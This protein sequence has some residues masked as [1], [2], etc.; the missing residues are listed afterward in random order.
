MIHIDIES[1]SEINVNKVG[2]YCY[3]AHPSTEILCVA[4]AN[5]DTS[6]QIWKPVEGEPMPYTL[7]EGFLLGNINFCAHNAQFERVMFNGPPGKKLSI[8][9]TA[10]ERWY[11]TAAKAAYHSLPRS[12]ENCAR[13][14]KCQPK[15]GEGKFAMYAISKPRKPTVNNKATRFLPG[16]FP[17]K[18]EVL[19]KYCM[20]DVETERQID[21]TLPALP[22]FERATFLMDQKINERGIRVDKYL[23]E[24]IVSL[25]QTQAEDLK[26]KFIDLTGFTPKQIQKFLPW[27]RE[28]GYPFH[29][30]T[31][32]SVNQAL[33]NVK[34]EMDPDLVKALQI[35]RVASKSSIAK[36]DAVERS[37]VSVGEEMSYDNDG[38][39][40]YT[41]K[42]K[43]MFLYHGASTGRWAGKIFQPHNLPR[44]NFKSDAEVQTAINTIREYD[45]AL[46][47]ANYD[48][49]NALFSA[50][51]RSILIPDPGKKFKVADF[52]SIEARVLGWI[53]REEGYLSAFRNKEDL[54][55]NLAMKIYQCTRE[56]VTPDRRFLGKTGILALGYGMGIVKF[57][58]TCLGYGME[59]PD[60]LLQ[61]ALN[62][63]RDTYKTIVSFWRVVEGKAIQA[64]QTNQ[65]QYLNG[66]SF[67][68]DRNFL[69]IELP[70]RR[71]LHYHQPYI[72]D[73]MTPW[74][75]MKPALHFM[76]ENSETK[77]YSEQNTYGGKLVENIVQAISRDL[78]CCALHRV[79]QHPEFEVLGH[80]HDEI[81]AQS[82]P[83]QGDIQEYEK[84]MT[85]IPKWAKD[86]PM[87]AEAWEGYRY[88]K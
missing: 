22:P 52:A 2:V 24:C 78:L 15:D 60:S 7:R 32:E 43:G 17:D 82:S 56:E 51:L 54:Y 72:K 11:C 20:G 25:A 31:K 47:R 5:N 3:A 81:I 27:A 55:V 16:D 40:D 85:Q 19:Y 84:I 9:N 6:I 38:W 71:C 80:V 70:S 83:G 39:A 76:G 86:L 53:S 50:L 8:P 36:Y 18:F 87:G 46:L 74:G 14:L 13:A 63:Y 35:R 30:L 12:L 29:D 67:F 59:V 4:W 57:I 64:V 79:E 42:I 44:G 58:A 34:E 68:M 23:V 62:T 41:F 26:S 77:Q 88:K 61:M 33:K 75:Q 65:I 10:L 48:S 28:R 49:P 21:R 69:K 73:K 66:L 1:Y 37:V 45:I